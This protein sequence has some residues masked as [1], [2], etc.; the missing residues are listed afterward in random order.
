MAEH[1]SELPCDGEGVCMVCKAKPSADETLNCNTCATPWHVAC[2]ST[3]PESMAHALKWDCPDCSSLSLSP[4][5]AA[6]A[7]DQP[8][9]DLLAAIRAIESDASLSDRDKA[10]RRQQL[11]CKQPHQ[12][13]HAAAAA[14]SKNDLLDLI[15]GTLNCSIC[16]QLPERPVTV[17]VINKKRFPFPFPVESWKYDKTTA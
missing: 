16:M 5:A 2:L 10:K 11:M 1:H 8:T 12:P 15:G 4:A 13:D 6:A 7:A 17:R 9:S 14:T 3:R